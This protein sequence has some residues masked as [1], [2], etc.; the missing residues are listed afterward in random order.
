VASLVAKSGNGT[1]HDGRGAPTRGPLSEVDEGAKRPGAHSDRALV[2]RCLRGEEHAWQTLYE[3]F[4]A[5]LHVAI[6]NL[7]GRDAAHHDL[8]DDI[9]AK[10][11]LTVVDQRSRLL[12]RFDSARGCRLSAFLAGL[13]KNELL[14]HFRTEGRRSAR[15]MRIGQARDGQSSRLGWRGSVG[16]NSAVTEFLTT[17]TP[18]ERNYC[19]QHLLNASESLRGDYSDANRWQLHRRVRLK[20]CAFLKND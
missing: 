12:D 7:L 19:E 17:L 13:A 10:V 1:A 14:R 6:R 3:L 8:V 18:R 20:L 5:P 2:D 9:A 11:W 4:N 16:V 15:E